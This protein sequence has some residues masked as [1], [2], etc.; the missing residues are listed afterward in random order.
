MSIGIPEKQLVWKNTRQV[1]QTAAAPPSRGSTILATMGS[2]RNIRPALR[3]RVLANT[4]N[5]VAGCR[6]GTIRTG[7]MALV[8]IFYVLLH[9]VVRRDRGSYR[10]PALA[11]LAFEG[12]LLIKR[13]AHTCIWR[14]AVS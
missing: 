6:R 1:L 13:N 10:V 3:K 5:I 2:T 7:E 9:F 12:D 4:G 8:F 11:R 14:F